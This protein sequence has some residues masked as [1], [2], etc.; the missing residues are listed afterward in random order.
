ML[1]NLGA[2][3]SVDLDPWSDRVRQV[4]ATYDGGWELPVLGAVPAPRAVLIRPDG[5]V[6]WTG[7]LR[8]PSLSDA[9]G[10]WFGAAPAASPRADGRD[11]AD[12]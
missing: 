3:E 2:P 8:D 5:H 9:M 12:R 4:D 6:A 7:E 10:T 1:L 11:R